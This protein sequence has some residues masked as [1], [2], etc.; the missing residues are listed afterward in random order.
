M[1][2]DDDDNGDDDDAGDDD[3]DDDD[4]D[5]DEGAYAGITEVGLAAAGSSKV[6]RRERGG[7]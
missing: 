5:D 1:D 7:G 3:D 2:D 4:N 6:S